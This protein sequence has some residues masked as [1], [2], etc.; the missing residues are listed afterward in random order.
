MAIVDW[1]AGLATCF[2]P[3]SVQG[4]LRDNRYSFETDDKMPPIERSATSWAPE[5]YSLTL[6]PM[7]LAEFEAFQAWYRGPLAYGVNSFVFPHPVT[8]EDMVW[9][10]VKADPPYQVRR[11]GRI[12]TGSDVRRI[13]VAFSIMSLPLPVPV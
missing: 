6:A 7:S 1:P 3:G 5:V 2:M 8:R 11:L 4:G 9:K 13:E 10:I 12:P